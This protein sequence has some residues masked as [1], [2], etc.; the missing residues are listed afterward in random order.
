MWTLR[1]VPQQGLSLADY[2][3]PAGRVWSGALDD[4]LDTNPIPM[5]MLST[6]LNGARARGP[7]LDYWQATERSKAA[8]VAVKVPETGISQEAL[9]WQIERR[10]DQAAVAQLMAR[11]EGMAG[12]AAMLGAGLAGA[13]ADPLNLAAGMMPVIGEFKLATGAVSRFGQRFGVGAAEG[14]FGA[15]VVE[16][17]TVALRRELGDDYT[18]T[19]SLANIAFGTAGNAVI[20]GVGGAAADAWRR[21]GAAK[22]AADAD[23]KAAF[24]F[25]AGT[26]EQQT[27]AARLNAGA[28]MRTG[29]FAHPLDDAFS[30]LA[31]DHLAAQMRQNAEAVTTEAL[32]RVGSQR[33]IALL[34]DFQAAQEAR[35]AAEEVPGFLRSAEEK[36]AMRPGTAPDVTGDLARAIAILEKAPFLR[37]AEERVFLE[38]MLSGEAFARATPQNINE[39]LAGIS[40]ETHAAALR[41]AV[42]QAVAGQQINVDAILRQDPLF[43]RQRSTIGEALAAAL[44]AEKPE[45]LVGADKAASERGNVP[46]PP[47]PEA[48]KPLEKSAR[49]VE[50]EKRLNEAK[51]ALAKA[52][53]AAGKEPK[54][55]PTT[56]AETELDRTNEYEKAWNAYADCSE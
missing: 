53:K 5:L 46:K 44:E 40:D 21:I 16:I 34:R 9:D 29:E 18:L 48:Q 24:D 54:P 37:T 10:R 26:P 47:K 50:A 1:D 55:E 20:R 45:N 12:T 41:A 33:A 17:P 30:Y 4:A 8:G 52:E 35:R 2:P 51:Q 6:E 22:R 7:H 23:V 13:M 56:K 25:G 38:S 36:A 3:A 27:A 39:T 42:A 49:V 43:G 14:V 11:R 15:G 28:E 32:D 31:E 19:D